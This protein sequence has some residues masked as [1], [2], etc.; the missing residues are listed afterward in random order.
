[1]HVFNFLNQI[2]AAIQCK[3]FKVLA[4]ASLPVSFRVFSVDAIDNNIHYFVCR[5]DSVLH[6]IIPHLELQK[7]SQNEN[8]KE[9]KNKNI[10]DI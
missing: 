6:T 1:M 4:S 7:Y 8:N 9:N 10:N 2:L 5:H 3:S